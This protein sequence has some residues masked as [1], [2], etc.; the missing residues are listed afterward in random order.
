MRLSGLVLPV[1][2]L[3]GVVRDETVSASVSGRPSP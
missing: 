2:L 1:F 3:R